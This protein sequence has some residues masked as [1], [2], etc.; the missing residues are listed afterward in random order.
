MPYLVISALTTVCIIKKG[1]I[2]AT[3]DKTKTQGASTDIIATDVLHKKKNT[4]NF[5][6]IFFNRPMI[7]DLA[8]ASLLR[9]K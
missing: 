7:K 6:M 5:E 3:G 8:L 9:D 1:S 4:A 2:I